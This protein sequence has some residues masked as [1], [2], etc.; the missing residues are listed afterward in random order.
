VNVQNSSFGNN[1]RGGLRLSSN[2]NVSISSS[3]SI[4]NSGLGLEVHTDGNITLLSVLANA[5]LDSGAHLNNT[6][7]IGNISVGASVFSG[8]GVDGLEAYSNGDI[9]VD[10]VTVNGNTEV[11]ASLINDTGEGNVTVSNSTFDSNTSTGQDVGL[12]I[13]SNGDVTLMEVSAS[14]NLAGVGSFISAG[15]IVIENSIFNNNAS[16]NPESGMGL[17]AEAD[18]AEIICSQFS[19]N[20]TYGLDGTLVGLLTLD[21]VVFGGNGSGDYL[22]SPFVTS[23]G[24]S[25]DEG[26]EEGEGEGEGEESEEEGGEGGGESSSSDPL[27]IIPLTGLSLHIVSITGGE[28]VEL[29]CEAF[30]GTKLVLPNG[31]SLVLPCPIRDEGT[32]M[33]QPQDGLPGPLEDQFE[34]LSGMN[35][36]VIRDGQALSMVDTGMN[37]EFVI[38]AEQDSQN[39][40]ILHWDGAKW[41]EFPGHVTADGFFAVTTNFTGVFVLVT[42]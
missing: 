26:G 40:A 4:G 11:G 32:L 24:C 39:L 19:G 33:T 5:N 22:G 15:G 29:D 27:E 31:D 6:T 30:S 21:D 25:S 20:A 8:N 14:N 2:G 38:P 18:E 10:S 16:A 36:G 7:G 34:F 9:T 35:T 1:T 13:A 28:E 3:S 23:G 37:V 41:V 17:F 12:E 42:K